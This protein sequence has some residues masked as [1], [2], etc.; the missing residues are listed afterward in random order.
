MDISK[1]LDSKSRKSQEL[2]GGGRLLS[3]C[4]SA[5][6]SLKFFLKCLDPR[7]ISLSIISQFVSIWQVSPFTR[8]WFSWFGL[9]FSGIR[10]VLTWQYLNGF[11][12]GDDGIGCTV[13]HAWL[14]V[15]PTIFIHQKHERNHTVK[16]LYKSCD[17]ELSATWACCVA[18]QQMNQVCTIQFFQAPKQCSHPLFLANWSLSAIT[19]FYTCYG[20][21]W[22][23]AYCTFLHFDSHAINCRSMNSSFSEGFL[24]VYTGH[25][26]V[27]TS[28]L[29]SV[30]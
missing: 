25:K 24:L 28:S 16:Q 14:S 1:S 9:L 18:L 12:L 7:C 20:Q 2:F 5:R 29:P 13:Q 3:V 30:A 8:R 6:L 11:E 10:C 27:S 21:E 19:F 26:V 17:I 23:W 22:S 15:I 4:V